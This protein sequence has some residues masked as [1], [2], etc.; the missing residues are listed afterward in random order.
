MRLI[1]SAGKTVLFTDQI[2]YHNVLG[3]QQ[4]IIV[5]PDPNYSYPKFSDLEAADTACIAGLQI[6]VE[7]T[8]REMARQL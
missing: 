8:A 5:E 2:R 7:E 1:G 3:N 6:A 4:A